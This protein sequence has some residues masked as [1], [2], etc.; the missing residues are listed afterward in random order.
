[1]VI[2]KIPR[3]EVIVNAAVDTKFSATYDGNSVYIQY[4]K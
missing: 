1:M 4:Q 2:E 3:Y